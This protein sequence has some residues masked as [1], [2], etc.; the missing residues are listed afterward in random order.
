MKLKKVMAEAIKDTRGEQTISIIIECEDGKFSASAP[1]GKSRGEYEAKPWNK[2]I[3]EDIKFLKG[4]DVKKFNNVELNEFDDL[5]KVE[6]LLRGKIGANSMIALEYC[7]LKYLSKKNK[8]PVWKLINSKAKKI[9][10]PVGNAIGGGAHNNWKITRFQ[11]FEFIP[12][13]QIDKAVK[14]NIRAREN[15]AEVIRNLDSSFREQT[16]DENAWKTKFDNGQIINIMKDVREN[17][18]DEFGFKLHIGIDVA[19]SE[20]YSMGKY[21]Y[22]G[23]KISREEQ[24]KNMIKLAD[25]FYYLE[26]PLEQ[27]DFAGFKEIMSKTKGLI[28]GDDLT[29]TNLDRVMAAVKNKCINAIIVKP[30]Q[31]GSLIEVKKIV[32]FCKAN[33]IKTIF[34]HRSGETS[35]DILAD[36]AVGFEADYIKTGIIGKGRDEKLSRLIEI[37]KEM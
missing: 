37:S 21:D 34:S 15:C 23:K 28:V 6:N 31:N 4:F 8:M 29:A 36:L 16:S 10:F 27:N 30:N 26:D 17:I 14:V 12:E 18:I 11:E 3:N 25:N 22:Y 24:I 35:E 5:I 20:F 19:A 1:N 33:K 13:V 7:F 9:P 2:S 32:E